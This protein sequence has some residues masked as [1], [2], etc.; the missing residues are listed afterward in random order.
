M[1]IRCVWE[2]NGNDTLL[3][4][5]D[6]PG[7]FARGETLEAA[8]RKLPRELSAYRRWRG[9]NA[10]APGEIVIVQQKRSELSIRDADSDVIFE[11]EA[12]PLSREEYA[13]LKALALKSAEDFQRLYDSIPEKDKT[14]LPSRQSFYGP[15]PRTAEEM[16]RH[17]KSVNTYYFGE[18]GVEADNEGSILECR[19]RGFANLETIPD[20]LKSPPVEGSYGE[21]WSVGK[22][23]R[24]FLWHDRIHAKAMYR[25]AVKT[26]GRTGLEDPFFFAML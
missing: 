10:P 15:V 11:R 13:R 24:R 16:Y 19:S 3:Y 14:C 6:D 18:L 1:N 21:W 9:E 25:M 17:T 22:L 2:H 8:K 4:A 26:F 5:L 12:L 20:F 23:L 7:A